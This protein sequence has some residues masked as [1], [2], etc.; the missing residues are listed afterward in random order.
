V[1]A[2]LGRWCYRHRRLVALAWLAAFLVAGVLG[3]QVFGKLQQ[4]G[5]AAAQMES[6]KGFDLL[7]ANSPYGQRVLVLVDGAPVES[8]AVRAAVTEAA[9]DVRRQPDVGRVTT[10]YDVALPALRAKDGRASLVTVDLA[11]DLDRERADAALARAERRFE[12]VEAA[13][14]SVRFGG[15]L[16]LNREINEQVEKD[17][18]LGEFVS[19]PLTL[20]VMIVIFGGVLAA[21]VPFLG[22]LVSIA[23]GLLVLLG[24]STVIELDSNVVP[25]TT[26]MALA[27]A[28]DYSLLMVSRFREERGHGLGV[29]AAVERTA[30]TAGRTIG[31]SA[32]TVAVSLS[33]L[34][35]FQSEFY[36]AI[37]AAGVSVVLI[38]MLQALTLTPALIGLFAR[39]IRVPAEPVSA[40][41][42]FARLARQVQRRPVLVVLGLLLAFGLA[43]APFLGVRF[44]NGDADLLP[45]SFETRQVAETIEARFPGSGIDPVIVV[46]GT[47]V[48]MLRPYAA[49]LAQRPGV[50]SVAPPE[51]RSAGLS[52]VEVTPAGDGRDD[53]AERLVADLR[54]DDPG[55]ATYVTGDTGILVDF[56]AE[57]RQRGP[58][59]LGWIALATFVLL[60]LMTGSV[61]VPLKALV[62]NVISLGATFGVLV[63][64]FQDGHLSGPLDFTPTGGLETWVPVL[65]FAFAFGLS[66][67]YEVFLLSRIKEAYDQGLRNDHAVALGLQR[68]G[69]II[70]S[71]ALLVVIVFAG[72]AAGKML[73]IKE[74]GLAIALAVLVDATLV[75]CLLVPATMT[76]LGDLNWWAPA[77]LRRFHA[78][79]GVSEQAPR[80]RE[81]LGAPTPALEGQPS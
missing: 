6:I 77:P 40:H 46:A 80:S 78:R 21:G 4:G 38:A 54:A 58:L 53:T 3:S 72:F 39:R 15:D 48:R 52:V 10:T 68:S 22:A 65:V 20:I 8:T 32:M 49:A 13:G 47:S 61:L 19:L 69:R 73:G 27:L 9:Q 76:L 12:Q 31:F 42:A 35:L 30:A 14:A 5:G 51:Q 41:G 63:L 16:L 33:G 28:I 29:A 23:G 34:F 24:F 43:G 44:Q 60:F 18:R 71:A 36:R 11:K 45:T 50:A 64:I 66:M 75:R 37:G 56:K 25:V 62:M 59:A 74:M 67:D 1:T 7:F 57:V 70:T 81:P 26:V 79:F 17:T 2:A 55:F